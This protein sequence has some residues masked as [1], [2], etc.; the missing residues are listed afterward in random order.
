MKGK[1]ILLLG[2]FLAFA[3]IFCHKVSAGFV[4]GI[5]QFN[6]TEKDTA[7]WE[8]NEL[9]V[10]SVYQNNKLF[11]GG[12]WSEADYTTRNITVGVGSI[13]TVQLLEQ[14]E[15]DAWSTLYLTTNSEGTSRPTSQDDHFL[16]IRYLYFDFPPLEGY[17]LWAGSGSP[18]DSGGPIFGQGTPPP[19]S[20][21][22]LTLKIERTSS[23]SA[24]CSAYNPTFIGSRTIGF[25]DVPDELFVSLSVRGCEYGHYAVFDNVTIIPEPV[26]DPATVLLLGLG[27]LAIRRR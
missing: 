8:E 5:E 20:H 16:F 23:T 18:G 21:R 25:Q 6:G 17:Y 19:S 4:H 27:G 13:V 12:S 26:P 15:G 9:I 3:G 24:V 7:T 11:I 10:A 22:P 14:P 2:V 1:T